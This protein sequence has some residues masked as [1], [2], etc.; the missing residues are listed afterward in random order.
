MG[1]KYRNNTGHLKYGL[2]YSSHLKMIYKYIASLCLWH[3]IWP[4]WRSLCQS[5]LFFLFGVSAK[6]F[7]ELV[8]LVNIQRRR[9]E[10]WDGCN[11]FATQVVFREGVFSFWREVQDRTG[12]LQWIELHVG[13]QLPIGHLLP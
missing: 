12:M 9:R 8:S 6:H 10:T 4:L 1:Y 11:V 13:V 7:R 2:E 5:F 3:H